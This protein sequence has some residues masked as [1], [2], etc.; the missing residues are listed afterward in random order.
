MYVV[1]Q[2]AMRIGDRTTGASDG[3][4]PKLLQNWEL[5]IVYTAAFGYH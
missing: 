2:E 3:P 4:C 1:L 5:Y